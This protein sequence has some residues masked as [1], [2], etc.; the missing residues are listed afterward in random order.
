MALLTFTA[1]H[2]AVLLLILVCAAGAGTL[3]R[4]S[5]PLPLRMAV[6]FG[7]WAEA[8][9][10]LA[11]IG[12]LRAIP[13]A[14]LAALS[15]FGCLF[16]VVAGRQL[17]TD[18][19]QL[20]FVLFVPLFLLALHPPLGFDETLYHLPTVRALAVSGQLQFVSDLRF[21][22]FP[23]LHELLGVPVYLLAGDTATHL[24]S[25]AELLITAGIVLEWGGWLPAAFFL[26]SPIVLHL[27]TITYVDAALTMF[28]TA[29]F[30]LLGDSV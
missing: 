15:V 1:E 14:A 27:G 12:Q 25:L 7:M 19:R 29:G 24:V 23:R 2:L 18:N 5:M 13:I 20:L 10:L 28:V 3:V 26:G 6:G 8:L 17:R 9:F 11:A 22:V 30:Y 16:S 21:P 4:R